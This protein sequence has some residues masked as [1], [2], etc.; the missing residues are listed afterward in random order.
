MEE[1][2]FL[3]FYCSSVSTGFPDDLEV[4]IR[5]TELLDFRLAVTVLGRAAELLFTACWVTVC[6]RKSH[7]LTAAYGDFEIA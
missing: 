3:L 6:H 2:H 1:Q 5:N 4:F 7:S